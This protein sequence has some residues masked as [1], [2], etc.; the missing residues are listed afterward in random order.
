MA[1]LDANKVEFNFAAAPVRATVDESLDELKQLL[2]QHPVDLRIPAD[3]PPA[4]MDSAHIK[5]VLVHLLENAAKYSPS[6][7]PDSYHRRSARFD[8]EQAGHAHRQH[9]RPR[10]WD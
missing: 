6:G 9:R 2:I 3:L 10:P 8:H 4:R 5:E 7:A 1:Q